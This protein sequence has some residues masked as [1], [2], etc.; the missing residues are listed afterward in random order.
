MGFDGKIKLEFHGAKITSD[1]SP[2][3]WIRG[4]VDQNLI[5][6]VGEVRLVE[7]NG[8]SRIKVYLDIGEAR[9]LFAE[10]W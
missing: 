5:E 7:L 1:A 4:M 9:Q 2:I 10:C 3:T 6:L 8:K